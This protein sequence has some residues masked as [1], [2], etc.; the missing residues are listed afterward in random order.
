M[1]RLKRIGIF[2]LAKIMSL[3][4]L[5]AGLIAGVVY[6]LFVMAL[7]AGASAEQG[8]PELLVFGIGGGL[9]TMILVP[10][11]YAVAGFVAGLIYGLIIN[12]V[13]HLSGGLEVRIE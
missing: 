7:G 2:S 1:Q 6:G 3:L 11:A 9:I 12:I 10:F 13:L 8:G 4:G 5:F